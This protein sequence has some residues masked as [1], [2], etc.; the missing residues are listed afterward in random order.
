[1]TMTFTQEVQELVKTLAQHPDALLFAEVVGVWATTS[2]VEV[3]LAL[4]KDMLTLSTAFH[5]PDC[6]KYRTWSIDEK[7][8]IIRE[9]V[10]MPQAYETF[11]RLSPALLSMVVAKAKERLG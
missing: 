4:G 5:E 2:W 7:D 9:E 3:T 10:S 8:E 11:L 1:M 6:I